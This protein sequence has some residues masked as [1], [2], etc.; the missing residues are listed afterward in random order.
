MQNKEKL[1]LSLMLTLLC[2]ASFAM[3]YLERER[4]HLKYESLEQISIEE[5]TEKPTIISQHKYGDD[6]KPKYAITY[7]MKIPIKRYVG[8]SQIY[9]WTEV[10]EK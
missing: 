8:D 1:L 2:A 3:G 9:I 5:I 4:E 6:V 7:A 10:V